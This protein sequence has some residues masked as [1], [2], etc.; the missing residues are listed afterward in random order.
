MKTPLRMW[1]VYRH[2]K[3]YPGKYVARLFEVDGNGPQPTGSIVVTET[4]EALQQRMTEMNL[5]RLSRHP[6]D[7]R[8]IVETWI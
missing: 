4:L 3:D 2:P 1:T 5:V 8:V 6:N 7:D